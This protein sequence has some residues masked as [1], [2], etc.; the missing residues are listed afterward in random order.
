MLDIVQ[1]WIAYTHTV[2]SMSYL[3]LFVKAQAWLSEPFCADV[4]SCGAA[5]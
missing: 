2:H 4:Y 1:D 5:Y 3:A